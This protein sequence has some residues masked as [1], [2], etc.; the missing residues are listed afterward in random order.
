MDYYFDEEN[1]Y[2]YFS[3][4]EEDDLHR[5]Y[6]YEEEPGGNSMLT[7]HRHQKQMLELGWDN[8]LEELPESDRQYYEKFERR[9]LRKRKRKEKY[10]HHSTQ[11]PRDPLNKETLKK[12]YNH[13]CQIC[14]NQVNVGKSKFVTVTHHIHPLGLRGLDEIEN[15]MVVCSNCHDM[16]TYHALIIDLKEKKVYHV[17]NTHEYHG[18]TIKVLHNI[19]PTYVDFSNNLVYEKK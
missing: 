15:M 12:L 8:P 10:P 7:L 3:D 16:F 11:Y 2:D 9:I 1:Q 13:T 4:L 14:D 17:E 5:Q 18:K 6:V 19:E